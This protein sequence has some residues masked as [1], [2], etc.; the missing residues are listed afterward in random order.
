VI[1]EHHWR[2][3]ADVIWSRTGRVVIGTGIVLYCLV[4]FGLVATAK[5]IGEVA[6]VALIS[7]VIRQ[8]WKRRPRRRRPT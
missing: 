3:V 6:V 1:R 2:P 4:V 7:L 8:G 5:T